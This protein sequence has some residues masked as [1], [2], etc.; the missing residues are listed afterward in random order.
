MIHCSGI[1]QRYDW[2]GGNLREM[3]IVPG[4]GVYSLA[5]N[6]LRPDS[7]VGLLLAGKRVIGP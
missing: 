2:T 4:T 5:I 1:E 3:S 6:V 7:P